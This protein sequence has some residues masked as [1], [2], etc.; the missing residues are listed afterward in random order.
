MRAQKLRHDHLAGLSQRQVVVREV[1]AAGAAGGSMCRPGNR[2]QLGTQPLVKRRQAGQALVKR[3]KVASNRKFDGSCYYCG[4]LGHKK[5][6]CRKLQQDRPDQSN[7]THDFAYPV[8]SV[9]G[10]AGGGSLVWTG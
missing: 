9:R 4:L 1:S 3:I 10:E 6:Q 8:F 7:V 5:A 2:Q